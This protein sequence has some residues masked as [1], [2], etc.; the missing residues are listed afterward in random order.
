MSVFETVQIDDVFLEENKS[1]VMGG[2]QL[3]IEHTAL[4]ADSSDWISSH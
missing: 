1:C 4:A 3:A 2:V